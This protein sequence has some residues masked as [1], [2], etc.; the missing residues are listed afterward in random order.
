MGGRNGESMGVQGKGESGSPDG[1]GMATQC[2]GVMVT[3]VVGV[4][5]F[6]SVSAF[7]QSSW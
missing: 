5:M 1:P 4:S 2:V 3:L 6:G 7:P